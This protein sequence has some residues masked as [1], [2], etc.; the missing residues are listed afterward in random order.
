MAALGLRQELAPEVDPHAASFLG[1]GFA[2][3][4]GPVWSMAALNVALAAAS[5]LAAVTLASG[6]TQV[7]RVGMAAVWI[8]LAGLLVVA[9]DRV[10]GWFLHVNVD[11][12]TLLVCLGA[13]T[14]ATAVRSA[15]LLF[16][17]LLTAL[18]AATWF[19]RSQMAAHLLVVVLA[20]GGVMLASPSGRD[21][22]GLWVTLLLVTILSAYFVNALVSNL[23]RAA[24]IDP[25]TG[26]LNRSGLRLATEAQGNAHTQ[27]NVLAAL[28]LDGLKAI[29]DA[30][31]HAAGDRILADTG[32]V[33]RAHLR[34]S[35]IVA[36]VGGDEFVVVLR[37]TDVL[38]AEAVL[39][40]VIAHLPL[41]ASVGWVE[42]A[43][44][45]PVEEAIK[46]A[47][48]LMYGQKA[49]RRHR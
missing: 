5:G 14:A 1:R 24:V 33:M 20:S 49:T 39:S 12:S 34:P 44:G 41:P 15:A 27:A 43:P 23:N 30:E 17:L 32:A 13:A 9:K 31:G 7:L 36:R 16:L 26:L 11:L 8:L 45:A 21:Q 40:R 6:S 2:G 3:M 47:D 35:D 10:P 19:P 42:W 28:D 4:A 37:R 46:A 25:L 22:V 29:N 38:Q 48:R 18:Y